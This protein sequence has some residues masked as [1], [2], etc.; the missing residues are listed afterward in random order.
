MR[1]SV[2]YCRSDGKQLVVNSPSFLVVLCFTS[3]Q[4]LEEGFGGDTSVTDEHTVNIE[5]GVEEVF[6]VASEYVD[7]GSLLLDDGNLPI[8]SSHVSNTVLHWSQLAECCR[9][10]YERLTGKDTGL[11]QNIKLGLQVVGRLGLGRVLEKDER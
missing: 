6:V 8:P 9:E 1:T 5:R 11:G 2:I 3:I 7:V 4:Q 10:M